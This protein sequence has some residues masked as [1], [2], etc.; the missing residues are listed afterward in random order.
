MSL[1]LVPDP[2]YRKTGLNNVEQYLAEIVDRLL[3]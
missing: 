2:E 1:V 3:R